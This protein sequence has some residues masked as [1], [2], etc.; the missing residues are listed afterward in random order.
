[1]KKRK[2]PGWPNYMLPKPVNG[3]I[4]Y[5]WNAPSWARKRGCPIKSEALGADYGQAKARCD[6]VINPIFDSWR[7]GGQTDEAIEKRMIIGSFDWMVSIYKKQKKYTKLPVGSRDDYD[8]ALRNVADFKLVD[9][10]RFGSVSLKNISAPSVDRLYEKLRVNQQGLSR[11]RSA[12]L[13]MTVCRLAWKYALRAEPALIP[14]LNPFVGIEIEYKPKTTRAATLSELKRFVAAA[15]ADG[16]MSLG[17]AAMIAFY[18]L[19]REEDIFMRLAWSDYCPPGKL[20]RVMIWH[21]KN[22]D[23]RIP[24]P[25]FDVDGT[26]LWPEM[27]SRLESVSRTGTLIVMRDR[28]DPKKK[29]HLPWMTGGKNPMRYVQSEVRRLCRVAEL[30]D[31]ITFT[32]FRHGGHTDGADA[33]LTDA[34]MRA[35]GG[36]KTTAALLRYAKETDAQRQVAGRKRLNARTKKGDLSE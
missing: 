18:W 14:T 28:P 13:E 6:D 25:L 29:V 5:Y 35:L 16:S 7:T 22:H 15:D 4:R 8:R 26:Q 27:T 32:S 12:L 24:L 11:S 9:G 36:H 33:D 31:E 21:H 1:M 30:P 20:D 10:R 2:P 34:Q 17:T 19:Q 3:V 23:E